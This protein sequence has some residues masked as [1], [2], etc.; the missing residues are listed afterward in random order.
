[1]SSDEN[2]RRAL[3]DAQAELK[4]LTYRM[5]K[6]RGTIEALTMLL[7]ESPKAE[8]VDVVDEVSE[9]LGIS[10]AI[11]QIVRHTD[12]AYLPAAVKA[13][14][15][16][17][18]FNLGKYANASA[19]VH[20]T[21]KRLEAQGELVSIT[22]ASGE[23]GYARNPVESDRQYERELSGWTRVAQDLIE[24]DAQIARQ[25]AE[26]AKPSEAA[27]RAFE[28]TVNPARKVLEEH[29]RR[30]QEVQEAAAAALRRSGVGIA[31]PPK[32][33]GTK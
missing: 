18:G 22:L 11:R 33:P 12:I 24:R 28:E 3:E 17:A 16:E 4:Q 27:L 25:A 1:M 14:L 13:R 32:P 5:A 9:D 20:N 30:T 8:Q 10:D 21:L 31:R 2:Y 7:R 6:V 23:I 26:L 19:V 15:T 29:L